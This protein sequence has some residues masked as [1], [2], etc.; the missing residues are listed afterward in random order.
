MKTI[1]F[2]PQTAGGLLISV[3]PDHATELTQALNTAGVPAV[4]IG[5]VLP[6]TKPLIAVAP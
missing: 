4:E 2:D 5:E 6:S 3:A 1:L